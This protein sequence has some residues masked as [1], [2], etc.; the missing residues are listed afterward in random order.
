[1]FDQANLSC[2]VTDIPSAQYPTPA[3]RPLNSRLD[4]N[5]SNDVFGLIV[6]D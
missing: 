5:T 2:T 1:V 6:P 3:Q 4:C